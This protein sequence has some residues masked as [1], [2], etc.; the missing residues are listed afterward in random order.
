MECHTSLVFYFVDTDPLISKMFQK[1][2][3]IKAI[4][5]FHQQNLDRY[6][7][8]GTRTPKYTRRDTGKPSSKF[9]WGKSKKQ[10]NL[11]LYEPQERIG[12]GVYVLLGVMNGKV[13]DMDDDVASNLCT[14][15]ALREKKKLSK[16]EEGLLSFCSDSVS[17]RDAVTKPRAMKGP[18][19]GKGIWIRHGPLHPTMFEEGNIR[20]L[21]TMLFDD[22]VEAYSTHYT[23]VVLNL[24]VWKTQKQGKPTLINWTKANIHLSD[25]FNSD[26]EEHEYE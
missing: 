12:C 23:V 6:F 16:V 4:M 7:G 26:E 10:G 25:G 21:W 17:S 14:R 24:E 11:H 5:P 18:G 1:Q 15:E 9:Q 2:K 8:L 19:R 3:S 13:K 22:V 20:G